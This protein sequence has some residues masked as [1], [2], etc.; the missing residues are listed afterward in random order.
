MDNK[1]NTVMRVMESLVRM[2][3]WTVKRF[4]IQAFDNGYGFTGYAGYLDIAENSQRIVIR[5]DGSFSF[6]DY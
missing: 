2:N 6:I 3:G 1:L 5:G 4:D